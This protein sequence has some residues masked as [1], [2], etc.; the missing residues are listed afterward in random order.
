MTIDE[1]ADLRRTVRR[2]ADRQELADLVARYGRYVD[3][4][5]LDA[6]AEL[7]TADCTFDSRDGPMHGRDAVIDYYR[8]QLS[9]YTVTY[10][11]PHSHTVDFV[12]DDSATGIVQAHA[13]LA[14]GGEAVIVALRYTDEYRREDGAWKVA[15]RHGSAPPE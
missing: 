6:V 7:Y 1:L 2:L 14:I 11:Y 15:H 4:R 8:A 5:D 9:S 10:H 13:E 3:D 12:D